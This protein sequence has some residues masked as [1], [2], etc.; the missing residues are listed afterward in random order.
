MKNSTK[1]F[2]ASCCA[3]IAS[4]ALA[5]DGTIDIHGN[6]VSSSCSISITTGVSNG[7]NATLTL[8][9]VSVSALNSAGATAGSSRMAFALTSCPPNAAIRVNFE[10]NNVDPS[11]GYLTNNATD[12]AG[13]VEVQVLDRESNIIDLRN[14]SGNNDY[15]EN[16]SDD[17][18]NLN[19]LYFARYVAAGDAATPGTVD[20]QLVY[21]LEYR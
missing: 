11:N 17:A 19:L 14:N 1:L 16:I 10:S 21:T 3:L 15:A 12:P 4:N 5:A 9:D 6:V 7:S 2:M 18:G 8:P 13:N 20:T